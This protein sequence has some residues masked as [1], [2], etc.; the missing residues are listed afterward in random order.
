MQETYTLSDI[1][2][3]TFTDGF[4]IAI[5]VVDLSRTYIA[6]T[7]FPWHTVSTLYAAL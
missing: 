6:S 2:L 7:D 5:I 3:T 1:I 4:R